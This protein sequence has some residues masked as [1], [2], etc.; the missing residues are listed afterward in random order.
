MC[1]SRRD[2]DRMAPAGRNCTK[3]LKQLFLEKKLTQAERD[4]TPVLRD[5]KG[6]I[7]VLGI[8]VA[9]RCMAGPGDKVLRVDVEKI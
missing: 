6:I 3:S 2:G 1:V 4:L 8:A 9:S 5:D 7:G